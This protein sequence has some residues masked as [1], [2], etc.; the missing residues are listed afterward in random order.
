M[1]HI[2]PKW[3]HDMTYANTRHTNMAKRGGFLLRVD[4]RSRQSSKGLDCDI[5]ALVDC[6]ISWPKA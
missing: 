1:T 3:S 4:R 5:L 2:G 6:V